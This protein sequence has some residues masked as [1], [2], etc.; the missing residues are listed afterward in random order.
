[1]EKKIAGLLGAVAALGTISSAQAAP[2][3]SHVDVLQAN[4]YAELLEPIP[5][6]AEVLQAMD[7]QQA[8]GSG[9]ARVQLAQYYRHH[10]HHHHH[11]RRAPILVVPPHRRFYHHHHHHHHH[12]R[13]Y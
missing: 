5:N 10:H 2:G 6:A 1:M 11:W 3:P 8:A 4:S 12:Y 7:E 13:R 9:E